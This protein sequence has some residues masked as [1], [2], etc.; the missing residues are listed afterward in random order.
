SKNNE[1]DALAESV[2]Q[3]QL[4]TDYVLFL[5]TYSALMVFDRVVYLYSF[6][7]GKVVYYFVTLVA[8]TTWVMLIFNHRQSNRFS[9]T[10]IYIT[11][12]ASLVL[13]ARQIRCGFPPRTRQHFLMQ[14]K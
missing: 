9:V 13:S 10:L 14:S 6:K 3:S 5:L 12:L 11:K 7:A 2:R 8:A 4:P 1:V